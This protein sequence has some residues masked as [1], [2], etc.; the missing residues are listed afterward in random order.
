MAA[1]YDVDQ[2]LLAI[3][4]ARNSDKR[5]IIDICARTGCQLKT[6]PAL[7]E[8]L[9]GNEHVIIRDV[10]IVDLLGRDEVCLNTEEISSYLHDK[11]VLV[12]GGRRFHWQRT[13]PSDCYF[14][15]AQIGG[16]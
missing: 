5:A 16:I 11:T 6:V 15:S 2:I 10:D 7:Y 4:S 8:I 3:P 12:T 14:P 9:E 13:V 1:R